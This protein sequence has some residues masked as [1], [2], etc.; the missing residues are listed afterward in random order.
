MGKGVVEQIQAVLGLLCLE[1]HWV[2]VSCVLQEQFSSLETGKR[3]RSV[4]VPS[5]AV[6]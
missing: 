1:H 2:A 4:A 3:W 5:G 6:H